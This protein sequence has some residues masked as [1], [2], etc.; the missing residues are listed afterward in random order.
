MLTIKPNFSNY[1]SAKPSFGI[2]RADK[3]GADYDKKREEYEAYKADIDE[4]LDN[5]YV[6]NKAKKAF[7][8][9]K[10]G[11]EGITAAL[12]V[13]Y[14]AKKC[15]QL[16]GKGATKFK[17]SDFYKSA[18]KIFGPI[19]QGITDTYKN[20]KEFM[21]TKYDNF[22]KK[23][24]VAKKVK[25]VKKFFKKNSFGKKL[26]SM[27]DSTKA[28]ITKKY[29]AVK[30]YFKGVTYEQGSNFVAGTLGAGS[31]LAAAYAAGREEFPVAKQA[32]DFEDDEEV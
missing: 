8:V 19:K 3:D 22:L 27:Y 5:P 18:A 17:N 10:I 24:W 14:G 9:M 21:T 32:N 2:R 20:V 11:I 6:P 28:Y 7:T 30:A 25:S 16:L 26:A 29:Q 4:A 12:A 13:T 31:G 15:A 23:K 1:A